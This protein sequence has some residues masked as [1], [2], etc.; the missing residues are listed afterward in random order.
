MRPPGLVDEP[1][2]C[3][4]GWMPELR[5]LEVPRLEELRGEHARLLGEAG[6]A[7]RALVETYRREAPGTEAARAV[8]EFSGRASNVPL[9]EARE[10]AET[11][12]IA[13]CDHVDVVLA[14][15]R[16]LRVE[17]ARLRVAIPSG[18]EQRREEAARL[19]R[20]V[21][22]T[23]DRRDMLGLAGQV[24]RVRSTARGDDRTTPPP[25]SRALVAPAPD[26]TW[27]GGG[28]AA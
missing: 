17:A 3:R 8:W 28:P 10:R 27:A 7:Q 19:A 21:V 12:L 14:A 20:F 23:E 22:E 13:L 26:I 18:D 25:L 5:A 2:W 1:V 15:L 24:E 9:R 4:D 16:G 6:A 11:A